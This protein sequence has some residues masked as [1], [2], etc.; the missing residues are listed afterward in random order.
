[1]QE[2]FRVDEEK[3]LKWLEF[4]AKPTDTVKSLLV[5]EGIIAKF[6]NKEAK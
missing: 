2:Q 4:G 1:M 6:N 5:K 3:A